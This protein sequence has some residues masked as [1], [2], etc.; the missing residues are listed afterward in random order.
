MMPFR[1]LVADPPWPFGDKL[2]GPGRGAEK[3]YSVLSIDD[4]CNFLD[5]HPVDP[6]SPLSVRQSLAPDCRLFLW[7]VASMQRQALEVVSAWGFLEKTDLTWLK[8]SAGGW[9]NGKLVDFD[10]QPKDGD[11]GRDFSKTFGGAKVHFGMGRTL[12]ASDEKVVVAELGAPTW[13]ADEDREVEIAIVAARGKPEVTSRS[14]RSVFAAPYTKHSGKP[15]EFYE[16]VESLSSGPYLELFARR[17][18]PGWTCLGDELEVVAVP[19][20]RV[21]HAGEDR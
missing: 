7:R 15:E 12:R 13:L 21:S 1:T 16:L 9:V 18:R 8:V 6:A 3:N 17:Q 10:F 19:A 2:P 11:G 20:H 5:D 14:V 4:I